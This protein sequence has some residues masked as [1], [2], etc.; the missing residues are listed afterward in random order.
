[1][2]S[3]DLR[4]ITVPYGESQ[5]PEPVR[6]RGWKSAQPWLPMTASGET[7]NRNSQNEPGMSFGIN[8]SQI[9]VRKEALRR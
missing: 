4:T 8:R 2:K 5:A 3:R 1:M 9:A 6:A 7:H